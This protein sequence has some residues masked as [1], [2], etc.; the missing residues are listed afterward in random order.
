VANA[1]RQTARKEIA[2][3]PDVQSDFSGSSR[4]IGDDLSRL[5][6]KGH[7]VFEGRIAADGYQPPDRLAEGKALGIYLFAGRRPAPHSATIRSDPRNPSFLT[8]R[9]DKSAVLCSPAAH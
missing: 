8:R 4:G 1:V 9:H 7:A 6:E 5:H 3:A 2:Y